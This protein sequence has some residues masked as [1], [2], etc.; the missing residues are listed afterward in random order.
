M[1][2]FTLNIYGE[3]DAIVKTYETDKIR[4]GVLVK[5]LE[6]NEDKKEM[7]DAEFIKSANAIVKALFKGLTDDELE[8]AEIT[9]VI[10][11][12]RQ[13]V[14]LSGKINGSKKN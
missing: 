7:S 12:Y 8:N 2:R 13:I 14:N 4:Y 3:D 11:T 9:D 10:S 6:I 1:A 5:A